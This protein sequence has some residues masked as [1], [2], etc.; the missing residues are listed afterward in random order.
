[1]GNDEVLAA[2]FADDAWIG[3][4][5]V[6]VCT[7]L[8]PQVLEHRGGSGKV[9]SGEIGMLEDHLAKLRPIHVDQID[10][11]IRQTGLPENFHDDPG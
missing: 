7:N 9:Q 5:A 6:D 3:F 10:D 2:R 4:V 8:F 1:M 11:A